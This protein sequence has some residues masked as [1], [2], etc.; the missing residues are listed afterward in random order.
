MEEVELKPGYLLTSFQDYRSVMQSQ[1]D[2][3]S[4]NS[5]H[6]KYLQDYEQSPSENSTPDVSV[7]QSMWLGRREGKGRQS[8][9]RKDINSN[10][11][12]H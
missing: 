5:I 12:D 8:G 7:T 6:R 9:T 4:N 2:F 10:L 1:L 11:L 3:S